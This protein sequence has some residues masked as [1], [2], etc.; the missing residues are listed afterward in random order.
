MIKWLTES[1]YKRQAI[2]LLLLPFS[3]IYQIVIAFRLLF[4]RIGLFK[5]YRVDCPVIIVGNITV[6]GTGKTPAVIWLASELKQA[7]YK[8]GIISR[9]Y[10]GEA[11]QYPQ[12]VTPS[13]DP[14]IVGDEPVIISQ[15][16]QCP[17]AVSLKR[18]EATQYLLEHYDC[19]VI[20]SDDGLQ[21]YA[22][23]RDIEIVVVDGI[24]RFGNYYCLPAGPLRE[25]LSRLRQADFVILNGGSSRSPYRMTLHPGAVINVADSRV[26]K[27]LDEF[28]ATPVHS[29]AGI[30]HPDRFFDYLRDEG[31]TIKP[32]YFVD[33]HRFKATDLHFNDNLP[34]IMTEKDAI[35]C[36]PFAT[37]NMWYIP[38]K[39]AV[40][41]DLAQQILS[42]LTKIK[43]HG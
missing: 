43:H 31:L 5:Q 18:I 34:I 13:S 3:F 25:P 29:I 23:A 2:R 6:G 40:N 32:H 35:K 12:A 21:H 17:M 8:P 7:G 27:T 39:A 14:K 37:D 4:Y 19:D 11:E 26:Q 38:V 10:G 36:R 41:N 20:I 42:K 28:K 15:Q 24:R 33:H 9:G 1:W 22:L 30:G 16:T